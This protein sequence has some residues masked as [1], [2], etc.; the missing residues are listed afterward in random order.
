MRLHAHRVVL[1]EALGH[2]VK[3]EQLARNPADATTPPRPQRKTIEMWDVDTING[4]LDAASDSPY[5][6]YYDLAVLTGMRGSELCG[7]KWENVDLTAGKLM[8][9][10][11]LQRIYGK[12]LLEGQPKTAKS[13]RSLALSARALAGLKRIRRQ[14]AEQKL[15][16]GSAW[17]GTGF[18][19]TQ[20]DGKPID[21]D[22]LTHDFQDIVRKAELPHLTLH[23]L[24][25]AHATLLL[26]RGIHPKVV[27]E[28]LG[29]STISITMGTYSHVLPGLQEEAAQVLDARLAIGKEG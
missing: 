17:K 7:L 14:Q 23:G 29:H 13:R 12:G 8:V 4:F 25:H 10:S 21:P 24:R 6:G 2:A 11:T 5:R 27:S 28:R 19:F 18:V 16:A 20:P 9:V 3:R 26:T 15:A 22:A 1:R